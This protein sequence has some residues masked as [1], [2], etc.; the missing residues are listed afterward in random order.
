MQMSDQLG[1]PYR[2]Y[3]EIMPLAAVASSQV[4]EVSTFLAAYRMDLLCIDDGDIHHRA[5]VQILFGIHEITLG[6]EVSLVIT[7]ESQGRH[8][9]SEAMTGEVLKNRATTAPMIDKQVGIPVTLHIRLYVVLINKQYPQYS[10]R[11]I[12]GG[13]LLRII[14]ELNLVG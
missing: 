8:V 13:P 12:S 10:I 6:T 4:D 14:P 9:N 2:V 3:Q 7:A 5:L 1:S 11:M